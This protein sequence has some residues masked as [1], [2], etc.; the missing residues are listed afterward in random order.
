ML[1][2]KVVCGQDFPTGGSRASMRSLR[3]TV[4]RMVSS[5]MIYLVDNSYQESANDRRC[6]KG[7]LDQTHGAPYHTMSPHLYAGNEVRSLRKG[8]AHE[9]I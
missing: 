9:V 7:D 6:G 2:K 3:G 5:G 4:I 8:A 1:P